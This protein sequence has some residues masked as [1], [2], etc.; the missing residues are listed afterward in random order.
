VL[1]SKDPE[2]D[3]PEARLETCQEL[4]DLRASEI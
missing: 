3:A 4:L 1:I 2:V